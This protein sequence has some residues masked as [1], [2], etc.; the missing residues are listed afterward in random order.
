MDNELT[1]WKGGIDVVW[2]VGDG[3]DKGTSYYE[4]YPYHDKMLYDVKTVYLKSS[5]SITMSH[6]ERNIA[7]IGNNSRD[8]AV[9]GVGIGFSGYGGT[10][11]G[12]SGS[13]WAGGGG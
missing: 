13:G 9:I 3:S 7:S 1:N 12:I 8:K 2:G 11:V 5:T 4:E 6:N 10:T